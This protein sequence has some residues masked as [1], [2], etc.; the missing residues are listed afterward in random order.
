M[1]AGIDLLGRAGLARCT[2]PVELRFLCSAPERYSFKHALERVCGVGAEHPALLRVRSI[3][4]RAS[5]RLNLPHEMRSD[6]DATI[7]NSS[8]CGRHLQWRHPNLLAHR[9]RSNR[10]RLPVR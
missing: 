10:R 7:G 4:R 9:N 2:V 3:D 8:K 5:A 6:A 1:R